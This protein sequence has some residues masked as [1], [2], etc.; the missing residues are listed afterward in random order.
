MVKSLLKSMW[1]PELTLLHWGG[2]CWSLYRKLV[3]VHEKAFQSRPLP[4]E[5]LVSCKLSVFPSNSLPPARLHLSIS[6]SI[7]KL[8]KLP[9]TGNQIPTWEVRGDIS[10]QTSTEGRQM[11]MLKYSSLSELGCMCGCNSVLPQ[12]WVV[13]AQL[14]IYVAKA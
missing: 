14:V 1:G 2:I 12:N 8:L 11:I 6:S 7:H 5:G 10:H 4:W 3:F 9:S 13:L